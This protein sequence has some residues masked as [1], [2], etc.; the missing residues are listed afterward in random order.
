MFLLTGKNEQSWVATDRQTYFISLIILG[1]YLAFS[2]LW[3]CSFPKCKTFALGQTGR[4]S[5]FAV[6]EYT[7]CLRV[8]GLHFARRTSIS[9][10]S[11]DYIVSQSKPR[12][13]RK[14]SPLV[15]Y[16]LEYLTQHVIEHRRWWLCFIFIKY[17]RSKCPRQFSVWNRMNYFFLLI[18]YD[19]LSWR[20]LTTE[21]ERFLLVKS[22]VKGSMLHASVVKQ[23][24]D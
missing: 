23:R 1:P 20:E 17:F 12:N 5:V 16:E 22:F 4:A 14:Y 18:W 11:A 3:S 9:R 13:S 21:K 10:K 19:D 6:R 7:C 8:P 2:L 15:R 24:N